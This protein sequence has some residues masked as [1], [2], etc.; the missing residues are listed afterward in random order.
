[1]SVALV[2]GASSGIGAQ[3]ARRLA[4]DGHDL[5]VVARRGDRLEA[6]AAEVPTRARSLVADLETTDGRAAVAQAIAT[7]PDLAVLVNNAGW[8]GY[9]AFAQLP[10]EHDQRLVAVH[11][12]A[13][14]ELTHAAVAA[15]APRDSGAIINVASRLALS[16]TVP[17][18]PIPPRAVYAGAKA[19]IVAFTQALAAEMEGSGLRFQA[20]MP[21]LVATEFHDVNADRPP[22]PAAAFMDPV[23]LVERSLADLDRGR[24]TS[25]P[26]VPDEPVDR[27]G[28]LQR[29]ILAPR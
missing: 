4:A 6:L 22:I 20:L 24:V 7:T 28:V 23:E 18:N 19:F 5:I 2:T 21:G 17:P 3:Y 13:V 10:L 29:E 15:M 1:V 14:V 11:V 12:D 26:G 16:G 25:T 8:G 9:G 27:L